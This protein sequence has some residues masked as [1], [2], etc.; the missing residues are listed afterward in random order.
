MTTNTMQKAAGA[1]NSNG[2]H[3]D[4]NIVNFPTDGAI[5]QAS[6]GMAIAA[7]SMPPSPPKATIL[8]A[9]RVIFDP[10]GVFSVQSVTT[11]KL[12]NAEMGGTEK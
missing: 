4:T 8:A 6:D 12:N 3:T 5:N 10:A 9:L 2:P 7:P 1:T 11:T